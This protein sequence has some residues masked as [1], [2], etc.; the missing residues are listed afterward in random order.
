VLIVGVIFAPGPAALRMLMKRWSKMHSKLGPFNHP[1]TRRRAVL[2]SKKQILVR[3]M[4]HNYVSI[5]E[6][7]HDGRAFLRGALRK[8][9]RCWGASRSSL[10]NRAIFWLKNGPNFTSFGPMFLEPWIRDPKRIT[11]WI[12]WSNLL[13]HL[14]RFYAGHCL[15][16]DPLFSKKRTNFDLICAQ[17]N[18]RRIKYHLVGQLRTAFL[19]C[20]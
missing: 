6:P 17:R 15:K 5:N 11:F 16:F 3:L 13:G 7:V 20:L 19:C 9:P 8:F 4:N 2:S 12:I 18:F 1:D 10:R 14:N